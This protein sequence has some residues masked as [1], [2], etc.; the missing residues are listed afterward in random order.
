LQIPAADGSGELKD[1]PYPPL[2][3]KGLDCLE[4]DITPLP[5]ENAELVHLLTQA[6]KI[7]TL[8]VQEQ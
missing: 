8:K 5:H 6:Q 4:I 7:R 2:A 1:L 3:D